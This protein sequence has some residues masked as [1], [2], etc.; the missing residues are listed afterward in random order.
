MNLKKIIEVYERKKNPY[1][2][3][4]LEIRTMQSTEDFVAMEGKLT[5][6]DFKSEESKQE[7]RKLFADTC[8]VMGYVLGSESFAQLK[9]NL[10]RIIEE[11]YKVYNTEGKEVDLNELIKSIDFAYGEKNDAIFRNNFLLKIIPEK[12]TTSLGLRSKV[13]ELQEKIRGYK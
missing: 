10:K 9:L 3:F 12:I 8:A 6:F 13:I 11:G 1:E 7:A 2:S 5:S 4:L